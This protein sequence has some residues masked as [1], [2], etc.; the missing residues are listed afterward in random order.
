MQ[1]IYF[2]FAKNGT[3][4]VGPLR[5]DLHVD[6]INRN[7]NQK[8]RINSISSYNTYCSLGT[9]QGIAPKQREQFRKLLKKAKEHTRALISS[10][11]LSNQAWLHHIICFV[12]SVVYPTAACH[13]N[14]YQLDQLQRNYIGVLMNKMGFIRKYARDIV[15]GPKEF[16]GIGCLNMRIEVGLLA[17]ETIVRNLRIPGHGQSIIKTFL[18]SW[19]HV[20]GMSHPLLEYPKIRAPHLEGYFYSHVRNYCAKHEIS[21]EINDIAIQ[22]PPRGNDEFIMDIACRDT[23][24]NDNECKQ[25]YY[26]KSY[27]QVKWKSD[28]MTAQGD[29]IADGIMQGYRLYQHSSSKREEITQDRPSAATW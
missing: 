7:N 1:V 4:F 12:P 13:L 3:P 14:D 17:V 27:L 6:I 25:I 29:R 9:V 16:D 26:F 15:Y 8:V 10:Q 2:Q 20:S 18:E 23:E 28:L 24:I 11:A 22:I 5:E 21:I 19:Q